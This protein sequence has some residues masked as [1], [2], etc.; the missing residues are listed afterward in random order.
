LT[1]TAGSSH[2]LPSKTPSLEELLGLF[3]NIRKLAINWTFPQGATKPVLQCNIPSPTNA[4]QSLTEVNINFWGRVGQAGFGA[5]DLP[6]M[7][8]AV[9]AA[10]LS[11]LTVHLDEA[12]IDQED[13]K[14]DWKLLKTVWRD[15]SVPKL[16]S[17]HLDIHIPVTGAAA[18]KIW[19]S[20]PPA[21]CDMKAYSLFVAS[22]LLLTPV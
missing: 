16:V 17:L 14:E 2:R 8:R 15:I 1:V 21:R 7:L 3:P 4:H 11:E 9:R 20:L 6:D 18:V 22:S 12:A 10:N 5:C 13:D 19:A